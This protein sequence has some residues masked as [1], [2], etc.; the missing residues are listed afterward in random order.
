MRILLVTS[1][2]PA[3]SSMPGSPRPFLLFR[4]IARRHEVHLA[5]FTLSRDRY[6]AFLGREEVSRVFRS[7]TLLPD[8]P[9]TMFWGRQRHRLVQAPYFLTR[10]RCPNGFRLLRRQVSDLA[11][12]T[13]ADVVF[14]SELPAAQYICDLRSLVRVVD[15]TDAVSMAFRRRAEFA[16]SRIERLRLRSEARSIRRFEVSTARAVDAY[17]VCSRVDRDVLQSYHP[18]VKGQ[19]IPNGVDTEYFTPSGARAEG[20]SIVFTGVMAYPPNADAAHF[21]CREILPRARAVI[22]DIQVQLVGSDP[23]EDVRSLAG[24]GVSVTGMVPDVRPYIQHAVVYVCPLRF[25]A[26]VKNKV[27]A[28][29]AMAKPVVATSESCS[30]LD[31]IPGEHLLVADTPKEFADHILALLGDPDLRHR[32]GTAG[33]KLVL[34]Q[35]GWDARGKELETLLELLLA[36]TPEHRREVSSTPL[37]LARPGLP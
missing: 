34:E 22:P 13:G 7:V 9:T 28:A 27:L 21:L 35:Y 20:N 30:G 23:P 16:S 29:L 2:V 37:K 25:G 14:A 1:D 11:E 8:P 10:Y 4:H 31:V 15:A 24:N 3:T 33:R 19:C 17:L 32:L 18:D 6:D 5:T 26:G 12:R 36:R